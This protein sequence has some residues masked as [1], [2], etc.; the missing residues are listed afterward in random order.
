MNEKA[1]QEKKKAITKAKEKFLKP[2]K[3][4]DIHYGDTFFFEDVI[5][6]GIRPIRLSVDAVEDYLHRSDYKKDEDPEGP[7]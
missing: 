1:R 5:L 3:L 6:W 4:E 7:A 2:A